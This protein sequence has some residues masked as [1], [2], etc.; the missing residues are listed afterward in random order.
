MKNI[1]YLNVALWLTLMILIN[2]CNKLV[3]VDNP[4]NAV[5]SDATF[6]NDNTATSAVTGIYVSMQSSFPTFSSG[7]V[8]I[9]NGLAADELKFL[10]TTATYLQFYNNNLQSDNSVSGSY[11]WEYAYKYIYRAN[12][13]IEHLENNNVLT[14][15]VKN[16]LLGEVYFIR[17]FCHW[18]LVN[19]FGDVPLIL[20]SDYTISSVEGRDSSSKVINQVISD[21][22]KSITFLNMDY[23]T[24]GRLRPNVYTA[25]ALLSRVYLYENDWSEA[26]QE[27]SSII[28]SGLYALENNLDNVFLA[29]SNE[30]I[31]QLEPNEGQSFNTIE[32]YRFIPTTA[33]TT[34]PQYI[35][36]DSLLNAFENGDLRRLHWIGSKTVKSITYYYPYKYKVRSGTTLTEYLVMFRLA[37][38]YLIRAEARAH[39]NDITGA[40]LDINII[41]NR[42]GLPNLTVTDN[43]LLLS[44]IFK[45][46]R[47]ELFAEWG[48]RWFDLKRSHLINSVLAYKPDWSTN[49]TIFPIPNSQI[50]INSKLIQNIG[51]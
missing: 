19:C 47:I 22:K 48:N 30:A 14:T 28:N 6:T 37:E 38:Q 16:Q 7:A 46:R 27:S 40:L 36:T 51:Y 1:K 13:C 8:T 34:I 21:L 12:D 17:A 32:G 45:E 15:S 11:Y 2:A 41:R 49:D 33:T 20:S 5:I 10:G 31:W 4:I 35:L 39:L 25:R 29:T 24:S 26:E 18:Y 44:E 3:D 9:F 42:A 43:N 50:L 23:P